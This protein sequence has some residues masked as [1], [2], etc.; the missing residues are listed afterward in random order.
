M[1][2]LLSRLRVTWV[3]VRCS[4]AIDGGTVAALVLS[5]VGHHHVGARSGLC[6]LSWIV[7]VQEQLLLKQI[8]V[9]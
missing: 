7:L 1:V 2:L 4:G 6:V 3:R 9:V 8:A 5:K